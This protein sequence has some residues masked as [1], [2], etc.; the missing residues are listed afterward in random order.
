MKMVKITVFEPTKHSRKT[1]NRKHKSCQ[2]LQG[3]WRMR[4]H[5]LV[6]TSAK[7]KLYFVEITE[8]SLLMKQY[9][10]L[11]RRYC[12]VVFTPVECREWKTVRW[13]PFCQFK[14]SNLHFRLNVAFSKKSRGFSTVPSTLPNPLR[15]TPLAVDAT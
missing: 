5:Y 8:I 6:E 15:H 2:I 12:R 10:S 7:L 11:N 13:M 9:Q 4:S 3:F 1:G 14:V